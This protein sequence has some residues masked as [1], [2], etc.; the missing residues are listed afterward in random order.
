MTIKSFERQNSANVAKKYRSIYD[1][2]IIYL[3]SQISFT[4][5]LSLQLETS[6]C[7]NFTAITI[8]TIIHRTT[9][10]KIKILKATVLQSVNITNKYYSQYCK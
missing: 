9:K 5:K 10:I 8:S 4:N 1:K 6:N 3:F 2:S 7:G